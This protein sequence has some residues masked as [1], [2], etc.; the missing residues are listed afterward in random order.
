M[1]ALARRRRLRHAKGKLRLYNPAR[2]PSEWLSNGYARKVV[3]ASAMLLQCGDCAL[4]PMKCVAVECR[5]R[6]RRDS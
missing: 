4:G 3:V 2:K 6:Y 5:S 1:I